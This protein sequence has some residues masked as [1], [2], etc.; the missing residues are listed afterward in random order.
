MALAKGICIWDVLANVH[1]KSKGRKKQKPV[2]Q[3]NDIEGLLKKYPSIEM[4]AFIG[5]K[6]HAKYKSL[7]DPSCEKRVEL[8]TL[9][10]SSPSNTRL[11]VAEKADEWKSAFQNVMTL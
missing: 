6:A 2:D 3:P 7:Q 4:I 1:Q 5:Q 8:V 10:S 9:P 11:S